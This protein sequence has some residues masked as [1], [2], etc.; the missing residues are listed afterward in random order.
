MGFHLIVAKGRTPIRRE[1]TNT[2]FRGK[3][4]V[5]GELIQEPDDVVARSLLIATGSGATL[6]GC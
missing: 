6:G 2:W 1:Q 4:R 3:G 5:T